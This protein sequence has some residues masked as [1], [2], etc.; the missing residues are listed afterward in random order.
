MAFAL[1]N[2]VK[3]GGPSSSSA[4]RE[5]SGPED[6]AV[7]I[8]AD[9][10]EPKTLATSGQ[11]SAVKAAN[12]GQAKPSGSD[13]AE[14]TARRSQP[15]DADQ[16]SEPPQYEAAGDNADI[17]SVAYHDAIQK[18]DREKRDMVLTG[19]NLNQLL[20]DLEE[21]DAES[22]ENSYFRKGLK[23]VQKPLENVKLAV[24]LAQ[25]LL[26]LDPAVATATGVVK[27]FTIVCVHPALCVFDMAS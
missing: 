15:Q 23:R 4:G 5:Q 13:G 20:K 22:A 21:R 7:R 12:D 14:T 11:P 26:G 19:R 18:L 25:P 17:W 27:S 1:N 24:D 8:R 2:S 9:P 10:T 3:P 16:T 6:H